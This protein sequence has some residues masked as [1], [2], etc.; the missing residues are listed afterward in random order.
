VAEG[1]P[2]R[3]PDYMNPPAGCRFEPRCPKAAGRCR[4]EKPEFAPAGDG[5]EVACFLYY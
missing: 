5:H 4:E 1:I 3:I 2:G